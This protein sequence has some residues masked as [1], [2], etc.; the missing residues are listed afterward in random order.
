MA[1]TDEL[2]TRVIIEVDANGTVRA[3]TLGLGKLNTSIDKAKKGAGQL[4]KS[5]EGA[6]KASKLAGSASDDLSKEYKRLYSQILLVAGPVG[7]GG[8]A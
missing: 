1:V 8:G 4:G 7:A 2:L 5:L 6:A 3:A